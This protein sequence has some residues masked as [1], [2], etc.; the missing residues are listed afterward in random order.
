M[1]A[2]TRRVFLG[3]AA[4]AAPLPATGNTHPR[5]FVAALTAL[6]RD[7]ALDPGLV[8]DLLAWYREAGVDGVLVLG[9]TGEFHAFSA[10]ERKRILET[11]A[12][13]KGSLE[14][15]CQVATPNLPETLELLAHAAGHGADLALC[16]PPFYVKNP[17]VGG[18]ARFFEPVLDAAR[19]PVLVYNIPAMSGIAI[20][21]DLLHRLE[22]HPKL[23][24]VKDSTGKLDST[25]GFAREFPKLKIFCGSS[26]I[27]HAA[28]Q[29]GAAGA[30][31]ANGNVLARQTAALV[32]AFRQ[33]KDAVAWQTK[34]NEAAGIL[35]GFESIPAMKAA[36]APLGMRESYCRPPLEDFPAALRAGLE[37][38]IARLR[39]FA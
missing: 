35:R 34:L 28:L 20:T 24:G 17:S 33:G 39:Q 27:L 32:G 18:L 30:I 13:H 9:T 2:A 11:Y 14:L 26:A 38:R 4:T 37:E 21:H 12:R 8:R 19:V 10:A 6:G 23:Y 29:A 36:L 1:I 16:L 25:S 5:F 31:T 15:M 3:A 7:R 22:G